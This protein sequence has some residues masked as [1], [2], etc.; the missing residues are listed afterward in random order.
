MNNSCS[1]IVSLLKLLYL[2]TVQH[3]CVV[4]VA[5]VEHSNRTVEQTDLQEK[6][7][8]KSVDEARKLSSLYHSF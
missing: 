3:G 4:C 1:G 2:Q 6:S 7:D 8:M 5:D